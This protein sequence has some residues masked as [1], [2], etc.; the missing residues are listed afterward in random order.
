MSAVLARMLI[1][2][3]CMLLFGAGSP[4]VTADEPTEVKLTSEQ[5]LESLAM[6]GWSEDTRSVREAAIRVLESRNKTEA[7]TDS[8]CNTP[9]SEVWVDLLVGPSSL[10]PNWVTLLRAWKTSDRSLQHRWGYGF[11]GDYVIR[12]DC[13]QASYL[14]SGR[15]VDT[16]TPFKAEAHYGLY[17]Q[18]AL[19][20]VVEKRVVYSFPFTSV[21]TPT[22]Q[23]SPTPLP[24]PTATPTLNLPSFVGQRPV[25]WLRPGFTC[26]VSG[27]TAIPLAARPTGFENA[28]LQCVTA[29]G[30][31]AYVMP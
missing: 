1:V 6:A 4:S 17:R 23:P 16:T 7:I 14:A 30:L 12:T 3:F 13:Y 26:P 18:G 25:V 27:Y 9:P 2:A 24:T 8:L 21:A 11:G 29:G 5:L 20:P 28:R 22:L 31:A 10:G 19:T 15:R